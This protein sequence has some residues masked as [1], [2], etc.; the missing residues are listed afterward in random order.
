MKRE[1]EFHADALPGHVNPDDEAEGAPINYL[2]LAIRYKWRLLAG[3]IAG[4]ILGHLAYLRSGPEYDAFSQILVS[5]KFTPPV[6]DEDRYL[7]SQGKPSE[8]IPL[9]SSPLLIEK[10][11]RLGDLKQLSILRGETDL[12]E[13]IQ[14]GLKVKRTAG[15]DRSAKTV[16]EIRFASPQAADSRKVVESVIAAYGE[17]LKESSQEQSAEVQRLA[18]KTTEEMLAKLHQTEKAHRDFILTVPEEFRAALGPRT[19]TTQSSNIAPEDVI[20]SLGEEKNRN[21]VR[22]AEL[23]ARQKSIEKSIAS[24]EPRD[25]LELQVRRFLSLDGRNGDD[26]GPSGEAFRPTKRRQGVGHGHVRLRPTRGEGGRRRRARHTLARLGAPQARLGARTAMVIVVLAA[27]FGAGT[28]DLR[29]ERACLRMK[30]ALARHQADAEGRH[31]GAVAAKPSREPGLVLVRDAAL[32]ACDEAVLT[33]ANARLHRVAGGARTPCRSR[34]HPR[35]HRRAA[36]VGSRG[37]AGSGRSGAA[38]RSGGPP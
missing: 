22:L 23:T 38:R 12:V 29:V 14:D 17:Y 33:R 21:R 10:A 25:S 8:D 34:L 1:L 3:A 5:R 9:I 18:K 24:G 37:V 27:L 15:N 32:L 36:C 26:A 13:S 7:T 30:S 28:A 11:V 2:Q 4:L 20:H 6:R 31:V 19:V 35:I 16:L